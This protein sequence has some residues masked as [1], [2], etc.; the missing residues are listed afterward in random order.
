M[1]ISWVLLGRGFDWVVSWDS[2]R[3]S[4]MAEELEQMLR[5]CVLTDEEAKDVL[6]KGRDAY[7]EVA[8]CQMS[9]IGKVFGEKSVNHSGIKSFASNLWPYVKNLKVVEIGINM[10]QFIFSNEKDMN[11]VLSGRPWIYDN[12]FL[13][14]VPWKEGVEQDEGAFTKT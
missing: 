5:R 13:V 8:E 12:M 9:I 11:R 14:L 3:I 2:L 4:Q 1:V 7:Q 10:F 6:L